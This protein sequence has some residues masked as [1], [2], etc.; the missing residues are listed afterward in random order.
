MT[1]RQLMGSRAEWAPVRPRGQGRESRVGAA[2]GPGAVSLLQLGVDLQRPHRQ[3]LLEPRVLL[4]VRHGDAVP[5]VHRQHAADEVPA[6]R[7]HLRATLARERQE[8]ADGSCVADR[9]L[10]TGAMLQRSQQQR[11]WRLT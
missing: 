1:F 7:A 10:D 4:D 6:L 11:Q 9:S 3:V 2:R 8:A 5:R